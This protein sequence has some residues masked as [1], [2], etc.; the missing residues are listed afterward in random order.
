MQQLLRKQ[1]RDIRAEMA[2]EETPAR[3]LRDLQNWRKLEKQIRKSQSQLPELLHHSAAEQL[4]AFARQARK[5]L[6][7]KSKAAPPDWH[8]LRVAGKRLRYTLEMSATAGHD[9]PP[10]TA[11]VFKKMQDALGLWHDHV[12]LSEQAL[13]TAS[14]QNLARTNPQLL[15]SV[16]ALVQESQRRAS[17]QLKVFAGIWRNHGE[18]LTRQIRALYSATTTSPA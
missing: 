17:E 14:K 4:T 5:S 13:N 3:V 2:E 8:A 10:H 7:A 12:V 9:L 11:K 18:A 6:N 16:L 1:R 15:T